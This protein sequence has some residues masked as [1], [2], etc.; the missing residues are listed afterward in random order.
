MLPAL[1]FDPGRAMLDCSDR[2]VIRIGATAGQVLL[3]PD[4]V[5]VSAGPLDPLACSSRIDRVWAN[6]VP[7]FG[8]GRNTGA[9]PGRCIAGPVSEQAL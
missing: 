3:D 4:T 5:I 8:D 2:G 9:D 1:A 6:A 7:A